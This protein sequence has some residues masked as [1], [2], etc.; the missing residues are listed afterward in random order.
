MDQKQRHESD[1]AGN[2]GA[3]GLARRRWPMEVSQVDRIVHHTLCDLFRKIISLYTDLIN[4]AWTG[5]T[6]FKNKTNALLNTNQNDMR[7]II[8][9]ITG[10]FNVRMKR[11]LKLSRIF[12]VTY[13][14]KRISVGLF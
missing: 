11:S 4:Q 1:I 9:V 7:L 5:V 13:W 6:I 3:D 10:Y 14:L 2:E 12:Y 8:G